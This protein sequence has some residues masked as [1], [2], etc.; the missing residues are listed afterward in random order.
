MVAFKFE[1]SNLRHE[2]KANVLSFATRRTLKIK[3]NLHNLCIFY[4]QSIY[5]QALCTLPKDDW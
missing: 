2:L 4:W 5:N 1:V 3:G